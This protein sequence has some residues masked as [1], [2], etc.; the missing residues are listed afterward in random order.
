MPLICYDAWDAELAA[1]LVNE[2]AQVLLVPLA[3]PEPWDERAITERKEG[4]FSRVR[5]LGVPGVEVF[6]VGSLAG[7][8]FEGQSWILAVDPDGPEGVRVLAQAA[9]ATDPEII[10]A[11][12]PLL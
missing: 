9:T 4:M 5:E 2:G 6:G 7:L 10:V 3:N 1:R 12:I 11:D 8:P